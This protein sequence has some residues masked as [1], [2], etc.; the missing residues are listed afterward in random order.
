MAQHR[1]LDAPR[2]PLTKTVDALSV[3]DLR[4]ELVAVLN[5]PAPFDTEESRYEFSNHLLDHLFDTYVAENS[6]TAVDNI[7]EDRISENIINQCNDVVKNVTDNPVILSAVTQP[8]IQIQSQTKKIFNF[9][10]VC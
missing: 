6:A 10:V 9:K 4:T 8:L 5:S 2:S 1:Y 3:I 7:Q